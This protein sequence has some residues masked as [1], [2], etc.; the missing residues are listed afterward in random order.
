[1]KNRLTTLATYL[2]A[3][4][5]TA[6][7]FTA[8]SSNTDP[9]P[10]GPYTNGVIVMNSGNFLSNNGSLSWLSRT[11]NLAQTDIFRT[12]NNRPTSGYIQEYVEAGNRG[13]FLVDNSTAGLD[14]A[15]I[16][17]ADSLRSVKTLGA[18]DIENP[19]YAARISD[20]KVYVTCWG[21]TGSF[22]NTFINPGYV[23][24][25]DLTTNTI[26]KKIS[27]QKGAEGVTVVGSEAFVASVSYSGAKTITVIDTQTDAVKQQITVAAD[28]DKLLRDANNKLWGLA[29][30]NA[31]RI[32]PSTKTVETTIPIGAAT[33]TSGPGKLAISADGRTFYYSYTNSDASYK[34]LSQYI[35]RFGIDDTTITPTTPVVGRTFTG[36]GITAL[37]YDPQT[38]V[39]YAGVSPNYVQAG[40]VYRYQS[41]GQLVDSVKVEISPVGFYFK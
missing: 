2:L 20:T 5:T 3:T 23:A 21:T 13:V 22:P 16:V 37:G 6:A 11:S 17:T 40:Y 12:R 14:R 4:A 26:T 27:V 39:I 32:N 1:M 33:G 34:M 15:E 30:K 10:T 9:A 38:N 41:T 18:P 25:I 24:V 35:F 31:I 7:L 19:R 36:E 29:G 28:P 8:C